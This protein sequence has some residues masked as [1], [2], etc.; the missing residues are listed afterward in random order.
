MP[1]LGERVCARCPRCDHP[2]RIKPGTTR[3]TPGADLRLQCKACTVTHPT[4]CEWHPA[5][6]SM[7]TEMKKND[8]CLDPSELD[9]L[10]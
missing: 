1:K 6:V 3:F 7:L 10:N 9:D 5:R 4:A 8:G 2:L